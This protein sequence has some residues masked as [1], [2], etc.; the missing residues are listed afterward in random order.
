MQSP[1]LISVFEKAG[2]PPAYLDGPD[3]ARFIET[4]SARL[5]PAVRKIGKVE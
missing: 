5:I 3:F 4:D 1:Q 2:S